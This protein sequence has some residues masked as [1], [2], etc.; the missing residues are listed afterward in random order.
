MAEFQPDEDDWDVYV[1]RL[2][3]FFTA[4][5]VKNNSKV[6]VLI[7]LMG[8]KAYQKLRILCKPASPDS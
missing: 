1:E 7:T 3:M 4:N 2:K 5:G 6:A 8:Q